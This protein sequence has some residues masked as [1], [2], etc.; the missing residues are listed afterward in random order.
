M[1]TIFDI[2][3][4]SILTID[5]PVQTLSPL[6]KKVT[7]CKMQDAIFY[8]SEKTNTHAR[9]FDSNDNSRP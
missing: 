1:V 5:I 3:I 6:S 7:V 2:G 4:I 8:V 9:K